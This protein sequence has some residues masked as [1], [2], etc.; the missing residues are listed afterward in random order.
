MLNLA[1][2]DQLIHLFTNHA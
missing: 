1:N 2:P